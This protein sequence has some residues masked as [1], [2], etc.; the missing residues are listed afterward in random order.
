MKII[1]FCGSLEPGKDGVGDYTRRLA[2]ELIVQGHEAS[3]VA[4]NDY[5][6]LTLWSGPQSDEDIKIPV[7]RIPAVVS[8]KD[9]IWV[10]TDYVNKMQPEWISF[11]F[12]LFSFH[13]KGII[14][15]LYQYFEELSKGIKC[16]I[17][18]HELWVGM[19]AKS[20]FKLW[21]LGM[22]QK[23][24]I[25]RLLIRLKP[26]AIHTQTKIY[27]EQLLNLGFK[28]DYLPLFTNIVVSHEV[29]EKNKQDEVNEI[30]FVLYGYI[31]PNAPVRQFAMELA[32]YS[33]RSYSSIKLKILGR[34][35]SEQFRWKETFRSMGLAVEVLGERSSAQISSILSASTYG[36]TTT[37]IA[38]AGKSGAVATM[39]AHGL[40]VI[41]V[42]FPWNLKRAG[43]ILHYD[44]ITEFVTG[45]HTLNKLEKVNHAAINKISSVAACFTNSLSRFS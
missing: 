4:L 31:H 16:H 13:K 3:V 5:Y 17:M 22:V 19:E 23:T 42:C 34:S 45:N 38:L 24:Q 8:W 25:K 44:G 9:R 7:V 41:S 2:G 43:N 14:T 33:K 18:F 39:W 1:F 40:K 26:K 10:A 6:T 30:S 29:N 21:I 27:Q 35:G 37:P 28:A 36:V 12:V 11:Q 15:G 32:D 20:K